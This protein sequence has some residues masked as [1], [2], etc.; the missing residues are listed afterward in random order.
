[1]ADS[2]SDLRKLFY[3]TTEAE[4]TSL[5][6]AVAAGKTFSTL[7]DSTTEGFYGTTPIAQPAG[8]ANVTGGTIIDIEARAAINSIITKL[9][10]LGL[11]ATV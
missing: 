4:L 9:E 7:V 11:I 5:R 6:S 8:L 2:L 10:Q 1:M 3:G